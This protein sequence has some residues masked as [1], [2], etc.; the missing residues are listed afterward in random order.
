MFWM[1]LPLALGLESGKPAA[2]DPAPPAAPATPAPADAGKTGLPSDSA[3]P[4][5][6]TT[7]TPTPTAP[8]TPKSPT[9]ATPKA[10]APPTSVTSKAT[11]K[12]GKAAAAKKSPASV[13]P[14]PKKNL[15]KVL[16][17]L[18]N[19]RVSMDF[20]G[21]DVDNA[22]LLFS[23]WAGVTIVKDPGLTGP[24]NL[25]QGK[26]VP[27]LD[28]FRI[29]E[30][31]LNQ[32]GYTIDRDGPLLKINPKASGGP[33]A[34][35]GATPPA[36]EPPKTEPPKPS[37]DRVT[38]LFPLQYASAQTVARIINEL[39][40]AAGGPP[41]QPGQPP[42]PQPQ[43]PPGGPP[44]APGTLPTK[45]ASQVKAT[46]DFDTNQVI[47]TG[48]PTI[49]DDVK[50]VVDQ[51]DRKSDIPLETRSWEIQYAE[52]NDV[53]TQVAALLSSIT[54]TG[55]TSPFQDVPFERRV[56]GG[57]GG[58]NPFGSNTGPQSLASGRVMSDPRTNSL[59]VVASTEALDQVDTLVKRLDKKVEYA[60]TT[61]LIPLKHIEA[62]EAT[63]V[64]GQLF[65]RRQSGNDYNPFFPFG[66]GGN[67]NQNQV[68]QRRRLGDS[69]SPRPATGSRQQNNPFGF[70]SNEGTGG[71]GD[72][73]STAEGAPAGSQANAPYVTADESR[74]APSIPGSVTLDGAQLAQWWYDSQR[75]S[76]PKT[77]RD[78]EGRV[79]PLVDLEGKITL[80]PNLNSND[81]LVNTNPSNLE[82]LKRVIALIDVPTPQ[83]LIEGIIVE[84]SLDASSKLG[85]TFSWTENPAFNDP[86]V[87][88]RT[89]VNLPTTDPQGGLKFTVLGKSF[90]A[91]ANAVKSDR[92]FNVLSTP[93]IFTQ[94]NRQAAISIGQDVPILNSQQSFGS[95][96]SSIEFKNVGVVLDVTPHITADGNVNI[97]VGQ[98][99][100]E[101][102]GF[103]T[104]NNN[105]VPIISR[106]STETT[107]SLK[108]GQ[109][110]V[111]GG[112]IRD[113]VQ[114]NSSRI[115]ILG[116]LPLIGS[117]FRSK[118]KSH[119]K[120]ELM[121][122]LRAHVVRYS[123]EVD[124]LTRMQ[125]DEA[126]IKPG[127]L[128]G[129]HIGLDDVPGAPPKEVPKGSGNSGSGKGSVPPI[130]SGPL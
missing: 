50:E 122:F 124:D 104:L 77:G 91:V 65:Q 49:M 59:T 87:T 68:R 33:A 14:P 56:L 88:Q 93:R 116:D 100:N 23:A 47:V 82:A 18:P 83:V 67:N 2:H 125:R 5:A 46:A 57:G 38:K 117:L 55:R 106:R 12:T 109:A 40:G 36:P 13:K 119:S 11:P 39:F 76:G 10:T 54:G 17:P 92:R 89:T 66:G 79:R 80:V 127:S 85:V 78:E 129:R 26:E 86:S 73:V 43:P 19:K 35:P 4:P 15:A 24:I 29:L 90:D 101:I 118:D 75:D 53:A 69:Q 9:A 32:K 128:G 45:K 48:D 81:L 30:A 71:S 62:S 25:I 130:L 102:A 31:V 8:A 95:T 37:V 60:S 20:R 7:A 108:D 107:V 61:F 94:N 123:D 112:L 63:F 64:L 6:P 103:T 126:G 110:I 58:Y 52:V 120:T 84:A 72:N 74:P 27:L 41:G 16:G 22:L 111:L 3:T 34:P 105:Q 21:M 114:R 70:S 121:V 113:S 42:Q 98:D 51:L 99:A 28:A 97:E 96:A 44:A 115:P 1:T